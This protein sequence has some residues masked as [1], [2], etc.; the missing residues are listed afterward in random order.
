MLRPKQIRVSIA[1]A[2]GLLSA[3]GRLSAS[4]GDGFMDNIFTPQYYIGAAELQDYAAGRLGVVTPTYWRVYHYLAYRALTGHPL[5]K[6]ELATLKVN[7][8]TVGEHSGGWDTGGDET[9]NGV[10]AWLKARGAVAGASAVRVA[11]DTE[12]GDF[13]RIVNCPVDAFDR[14]R[15][16]LAQ[17]V[18][19]GGQQ[20]AAVWLANQDAVFANCGPD[21]TQ[22]RGVKPLVRPLTLPRPLPAKAPAWLQKDVDYQR[23]AAN[24]YGGR[25][26]E[27][28]AQFQAIARDAGSPWQSIGNYL[29]ARALIRSVAAVATGDETEQDKRARLETLAKARTELAV[30]ADYAPAKGLVTWIDARLRPVERRRELSA[31]L[32]VEPVAA[33]TPQMLTDYLYLMDRLEPEA[34]I[35]AADPMTAWIGAM[36]AGS[37]DPYGGPAAEVLAKRRGAAVKMARAQWEAKPAP[38]WLL[39]L[40][41]NAGPNELKPAERKAAA[42]VKA[43]SPAYVALQYHLARLAVAEGQV[44]DADAIVSSL[45]KG[46]LPVSARNRVL[47]MKMVVAPS[48]EAAFAAALRVPA[49]R[50]QGTP[51][52]DEGKPAAG[53]M[54]FDGD[55]RAHIE[56]HFPLATLVRHKAALAAM[57][58]ADLADLAWGRAVLLGQYAV[59][60]TLTDEVMARR[61]TTRHLYERYKKA[62]SPEAK[63]DAALLI[64][65]N[66]P[67]FAPY[68][69][70]VSKDTFGGSYWSCTGLARGDDGMDRISPAF[71]SDGERAE[72]AKELGQLRALPK[73]SAYLIPPVMEW[74]KQNKADPEAPKALHF[75]VASTRNECGNG[76][77]EAK[78]RNYSKEAF[79]LLHKQYPKSEWA[80][81]T[82]YYY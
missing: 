9:T 81:K 17:R 38:T 29:A 6:P 65:A 75:L 39:A 18:V 1:L 47:R 15:K 31:V 63:R 12:V 46:A 22:V 72:A 44:R 8:Y 40:L 82:R 58:Q 67:E 56:L 66:A 55:V 19:Q 59:A 2:I 54:R 10:G 51:L 70:A 11:A 76:A 36:Q 37:Q 21:L 71:L 33:A 45:L 49:E 32:A 20:W 5:S 62:A 60:D 23:A 26:T 73:R 27:A 50:E 57:G 28:R 64:L 78:A 80:V 35:A 4:G 52:P 53:G 16:T 42:A 74:V 68:V 43:D 30:M 79:E 41:T 3:S 34:M 48:A 77:K 24:F 13:S 61:A 69:S 14:A 25:F 7:G